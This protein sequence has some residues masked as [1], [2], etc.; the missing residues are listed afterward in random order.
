MAE[1][2]HDRIGMSSLQVILKRPAAESCPY[3]IGNSGI[4]S[5]QI[6]SFFPADS[7]TDG[8]GTI[9]TENQLRLVV[10]V[11]PVPDKC[12]PSDIQI[13]LPERY[14][15]NFR[16]AGNPAGFY[17]DVGSLFFTKTSKVR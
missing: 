1:P 3:E 11:K 7:K 14:T 8:C 2:D 17:P 10:E 4:R 13:V 9:C 15:L 16:G 12:I 6:P 5:C